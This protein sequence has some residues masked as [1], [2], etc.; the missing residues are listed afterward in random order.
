MSQHDI[1]SVLYGIPYESAYQTCIAHKKIFVSAQCDIHGIT[2][3]LESASVHYHIKRCIYTSFSMNSFDLKY[4]IISFSFLK[5][6][7]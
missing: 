1:I 4:R 2:G 5:K 7:K 6:D 3:R